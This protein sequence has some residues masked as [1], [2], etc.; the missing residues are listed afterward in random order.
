MRQESAV[1][2]FS[3]LRWD[4]VYQRPQHLI[5][6]LAKRRRVCIIEEPIAHDMAELSWERN[7][8]SENLLVCRLRTPVRTLGFHDHHLPAFSRMLPELL[9]AEKLRDSV[10]WFYTP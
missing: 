8:P 3:H 6:R 5:S 4:F 7:T 10:L 1:V 2:V 9:D